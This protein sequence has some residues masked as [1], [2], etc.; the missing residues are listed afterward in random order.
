MRNTSAA[1]RARRL[2]QPPG[3]PPHR[4]R[5]LRQQRALAIACCR[6]PRRQLRGHLTNWLL[7]SFAFFSLLGIGTSIHLLHPSTSRSLW[8][9]CWLLV[10]LEP[11]CNWLPGS[12]D[13]IGQVGADGNSSCFWLL[14]LASVGAMPGARVAV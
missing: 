12:F 5:R 3:T 4:H 9:W 1:G 14:L 10:V 13:S 2:P 8:G 7:P 11:L 6:H